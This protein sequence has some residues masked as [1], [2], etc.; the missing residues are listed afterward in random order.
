MTQS[1]SLPG[2]EVL[3]DGIEEVVAD[4]LRFKAKLMIGENAYA[5]LRAINRGRELWDVLGTAGTGAAVA[6][7][8]LVASTFFAPTGL[9]G[10]LG[11]GAAV[12]PIGWV[13]FA[14]LSSG[15]A[16]YCLYRLL[17][18]AKGSRVIEIPKFLNTPLDTLGLGM[19][20]LMAPLA[21]R[22]S[23]V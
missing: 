19:F 6:S 10:L 18:N 16:C 15:G 7:S 2:E 4:P 14:A 8:S 13:A 21:L 11:I 1:P 20:D 9:L 3:L 12:T 23:D 17:G 5:S 22:L